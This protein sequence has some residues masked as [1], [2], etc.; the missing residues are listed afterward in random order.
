[1]V[2]GSARLAAINAR[3]RNPRRL[4]SPLSRKPRGPT[5]PAAPNILSPH[6]KSPPTDL[7][8]QRSDPASWPTSA[9]SL[10]GTAWAVDP[11]TALRLV[12]NLR[13]VRGSG[14][15]D[16]EGFYASALWL[17]ARHPHTLALNA[18]PSPSLAT[19]RTSPSCSTE[20]CTAGCPPGPQ[21]RRHA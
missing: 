13:C 9:E 18:A 10:L 6:P 1:V 11:D 16:R 8:H 3:G 12:A 17:H 7:R 4:G 2:H 20:S 14:M 21:A 19:S 5:V 15:S